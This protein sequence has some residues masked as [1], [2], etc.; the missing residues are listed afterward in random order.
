[1]VA[2]EIVAAMKNR[3]QGEYGAFTLKLDMTKAYDH[4]KWMY[5]EKVMAKL[6]F[7]SVWIKWVMT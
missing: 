7:S 6:E 1:M 4:V 5:L 3:R 2:Y